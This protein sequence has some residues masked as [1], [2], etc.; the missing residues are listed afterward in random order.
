MNTT[1]PRKD[2]RYYL[3]A[4]FY[5]AGA[6]KT[7]TGR[8]WVTFTGRTINGNWVMSGRTADPIFVPVGTELDGTR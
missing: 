1:A 6:H 2:R 8:R 5:A 4:D 3:P 7:E